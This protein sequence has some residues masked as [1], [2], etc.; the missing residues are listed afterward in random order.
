MQTYNSQILPTFSQWWNIPLVLFFLWP[1]SSR[2]FTGCSKSKFL[3]LLN[4]VINAMNVLVTNVLF[5]TTELLPPR[6]SI[7]GTPWSGLLILL[8]SS[9]LE[10]VFSVVNTNWSFESGAT[11]E[12]LSWS[13]FWKIMFKIYALT[14]FCFLRNH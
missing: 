11:S 14:F 6:L 5:G 7:L 2:P 4:W 3:L 13:C 12:T 10:K 9:E 8:C 1:A